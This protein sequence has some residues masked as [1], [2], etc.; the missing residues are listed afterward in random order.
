MSKSKANLEVVPTP[1]PVVPMED[2]TLNIAAAVESQKEKPKLRLADKLPKQVEELIA[3]GI[4]V[5]KAIFHSTI[6]FDYGSN[7][8]ETVLFSPDWSEHTKKNK[9]ARMWFTPHGLICEQMGIYKIIPLA[10]VKDTT[11]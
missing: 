7:T 6:L 2:M 11:L 8:P 3:N 1:P 4:P 5:R 9:V 10:M